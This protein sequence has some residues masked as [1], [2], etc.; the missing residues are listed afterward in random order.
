MRGNRYR[1]GNESELAGRLAAAGIMAGA[2]LVG[3]GAIAFGAVSIFG[4][5][6]GPITVPAHTRVLDHWPN[7]Y[8]AAFEVPAGDQSQVDC[9]EDTNP[10]WG[11]TPRVKEYWAT[12]TGTMV[13]CNL[14][15]SD[16][17]SRPRII[18][19]TH[20]AGTGPQ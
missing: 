1:D 16:G 15:D 2:A 9:G 18:R 4:T 14:T 10:L 20:D 13:V 8:E 5:D 11:N 12:R 7:Q 6:E 3:A 17:V 19:Q